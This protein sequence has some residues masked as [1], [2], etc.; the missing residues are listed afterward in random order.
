MRDNRFKL[1]AA[2]GSIEIEEPASLCRPED[3]LEAH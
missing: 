1:K 3:N 2:G